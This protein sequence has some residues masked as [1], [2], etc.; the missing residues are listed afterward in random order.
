MASIEVGQRLVEFKK[1][2]PICGNCRFECRKRDE[3]RN[4][5]ERTCGLH[6]WFILMSG[7]CTDHQYRMRG[8]SNDIS[9]S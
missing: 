8:T 5:T 3:R 2:T 6:G 4:V 9:Q 7:T 1:L